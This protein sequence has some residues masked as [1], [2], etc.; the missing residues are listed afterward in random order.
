MVGF[1]RDDLSDKVE[2][3][4]GEGLER[5]MCQL[6]N[7]EERLCEVEQLSD[8]GKTNHADQGCD[9]WT[10]PAKNSSSWLGRHQSCWQFKTQ[11]ILR[12]K[13]LEKEI[14]KN[15]PQ[16]ALLGGG[17]Y[18]FVANKKSGKSQREKIFNDLFNTLK[19]EYPQYK[20]NIVVYLL[21]HIVDF[22]VSHPAIALDFLEIT[23][24]NAV[25]NWSAMPEH[26]TNKIQWEGDELREG[27]GIQIREL[28]DKS[29]FQHVHIGGEAGVGKT[30]FA[31]EI[32]KA[33]TWKNRVL[34]GLDF[35]S[36]I[37]KEIRKISELKSG[38]VLV[39]D[40]I[41]NTEE[42]KIL[43]RT[44]ESHE[45]I[46]LLTI[47]HA[48]IENQELS[49][50][51][52]LEVMSE[53][54]IVK[55]VDRWYGGR[56]GNGFSRYVAGWVGG[57]VRLARVFSFA[58]HD[59]IIKDKRGFVGVKELLTHK[60]IALSIKKLYDDKD[61]KSLHVCSLLR[62]IG[63]KN[64]V[65]TEAQTVA[66]CLDVEWKEFQISIRK[67]DKDY[68]IVKQAGD[69]LYLSPNLLA[70][71]LAIDAWETYESEI[72]FSLAEKLSPAAKKQFSKRLAEISQSIPN[73]AKKK[74]HEIRTIDDILTEERCCFWQ[75][76]SNAD[77]LLAVSNIREILLQASIEEKLK[78]KDEARS[79]LVA[80]LSYYADW[81]FFSEEDI[82]EKSM[83]SLSELAVAENASWANN[84]TGEFKV[85]FQFFDQSEKMFDLYF[86]I[87]KKMTK[88]HEWQYTKVVLLALENSINTMVSRM[89]L[90]NHPME[91]SWESGKLEPDKDKKTQKHMLF[92]LEKI[93]GMF[94][95]II[96]KIKDNDDLRAPFLSF[97]SYAANLFRH[98]TLRTEAEKIFEK[99]DPLT[100]IMREDI[101]QILFRAMGWIKNFG[102]PTE[103][104][105]IWIESLHNK[106]QDTSLKGRMRE[107]MLTSR[108]HHSDGGMPDTMKGIASEIFCDLKSMQEEW[109]WLTSSEPY[110][111][112]E[113]GN[114]LAELDKENSLVNQLPKFS[115]RG[116]NWALLIHYYI[117]KGFLL[118]DDWLD[119][120]MLTYA[121]QN[122]EDH[123]LP[124]AVAMYGAG[125]DNKANFV[126]QSLSQEIEPRNF[127]WLPTIVGFWSQGLSY[128][129]S[130]QFIEF[131]ARKTEHKAI[132]LEFLYFRLRHFSGEEKSL[133][134]PSKKESILGYEDI[135][136]SFVT[137]I[138][139]LRQQ[140]DQKSFSTDHAWEVLSIML[141]KE[142]SK[143]EKEIVT[144]IFSACIP[145]IIK[146]KSSYID[147]LPPYNSHDMIADVL[148]TCAEKNKNS[149]WPSLVSYLESENRGY[150][151][152][153]LS[154]YNFHGIFN[155]YLDFSVISGWI[156]NNP[157][158]KHERIVIVS[159]IISKNFNYQN[160][161]ES[162][163]Q[164]ENDKNSYNYYVKSALNENFLTVKMLENYYDKVFQRF[165]AQITC[166]SYSGSTAVRIQQV[167]DE[168]NKIK[169]ETSN[170]AIEKF[171]TQSSRNLE[172]R[173]KHEEEREKEERLLY[174]F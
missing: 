147:D 85:K 30:R 1:L 24:F 154:S 91:I 51:I 33:A 118:G 72:I 13:Y 110:H 128:K 84:A 46:K 77:P 62:A 27:A 134:D 31:L 163:F 173:K 39:V 42:L 101:R 97:L 100:A 166:G 25:H 15:L 126:M 38:I 104:E 133:D 111:V 149:I 79:I 90:P 59:L 18:I 108:R 103:E 86:D 21:E 121:E 17:K 106:F 19:D 119:N 120:W 170:A 83:I 71:Y 89:T 107:A 16:K 66:K 10:Y 14:K 135:A 114:E 2:T 93:N 115:N 127:P 161:V 136:L 96:G 22:C 8:H 29:G 7:E 140:Y 171:I 123:R 52:L 137:D 3:L 68:H 159:S 6:L 169:Q 87:L 174:G 109:G 53:E 69:Y 142:A 95:E 164:E 152:F 55:I 73:F 49:H 132:A 92:V 82:L 65:I 54:T 143:Y 63:F 99:C 60:P 64:I 122:P 45:N 70:V 116:D 12:P 138:K 160:I 98:K 158:K 36:D 172:D 157:T 78:I 48:E 145:E 50:P 75:A 41:N 26:D 148:K 23:K 94:S 167:I 113:L 146:G 144:T 117:T 151:A 112:N 150:N 88:K 102:N 37:E 5:L 58:L 105:I 162:S 81:N 130:K 40:E 9:Y 32:C 20:E 129:V 4:E 47:G 139:I 141:I 168:L 156:E 43:R 125:S 74:L 155:K 80:T 153:Y 35:S 131:L 76:F 56:H 67:L 11:K 34:Y 124:L 57:Y 61:I 165:C 28:F 44:C